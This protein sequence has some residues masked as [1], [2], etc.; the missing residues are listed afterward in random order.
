MTFRRAEITDIPRIA[1]IQTL[2]WH[3]AYRDIL[4]KNILEQSDRDSFLALWQERFQAGHHDVHLLVD[5]QDYQTVGF[6]RTA[7]SKAVG[8][9]LSGYGEL[10]HLYLDTEKLAKGLGYK[11]FAFALDHLKALNY[12]GM[13]LWT[14][15]QNQRAR[16]FYERQGMTTDGAQRDDP[17]ILGEGIF[18]VRY[19]LS[20]AT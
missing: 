15:E 18:E 7:D 2:A 1:E 14:L 6:C 17:A 5:D 4:P 13:L 9:A 12:E 16:R 20:F 8:S 11:L 19:M 10:T 3:T